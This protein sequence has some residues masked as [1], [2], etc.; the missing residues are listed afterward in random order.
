M[1]VL[2]TYEDWH[3]GDGEPP[4]AVGEPWM[5]TI[6]L[7]RAGP[8]TARDWQPQPRPS[9]Q[10]ATWL[11][12]VDGLPAEH[13]LVGDVVA[14]FDHEFGGRGR[15]SASARGGWRR[16]VSSPGASLSSRAELRHVHDRR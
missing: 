11:R 13:E 10:P 1:D 6:D 14:N 2:V 3:V 15:R 4:I 7:Q 8:V 5:V 16:P 12:P 9:S